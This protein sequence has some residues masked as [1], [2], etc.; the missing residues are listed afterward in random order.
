[1]DKEKEPTYRFTSQKANANCSEFSKK[2]F[3][4][5]RSEL[6]EDEISHYWLE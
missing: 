5:N 3:T 1:M 2:S 4:D 6:T